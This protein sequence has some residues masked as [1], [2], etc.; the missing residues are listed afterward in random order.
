MIGEGIGKRVSTK[1]YLEGTLVEDALNYIAITGGVGGPPSAQIRIV[2]TNTARKI[3]PRTHV[4]VFATDPWRDESTLAPG[5]DPF[6]L[7]FEGEVLGRGFDRLNDN[8]SLTLHCLGLSN[9]W[10]GP[11][12][13]WFDLSQ[14][15]GEMTANI[16]RV[17]TGNNLSGVQIAV[18]ANNIQKDTYLIRKLGNNTEDSY[19]EAIISILDDIGIVNPFYHLVRNRYRITDR[20]LAKAAGDV[21]KL[22][23]LEAFLPWLQ[24]MVGKQGTETSLLQMI[25]EFLGIIYHEYVELPCPSLVMGNPPLRD[26]YGNP[27]TNQ[28]GLL[29]PSKTSEETV[30]SFL[31]KPNLYMLSPPTCNVLYPN[32]Y[33]KASYLNNFIGETTRLILRPT[34]PENLGG[35]LFSAVN[36]IARPTDLDLFWQLTKGTQTGG[37]Y[38]GV[39][40]TP[41]GTLTT[42]GVSSNLTPQ[43][44]TFNDFD[45]Y[46]NEEKIRG[47][48]YNIMPISPAATIFALQKGSQSSTVNY[49]E[50]LSQY[51][52]NIASYEYYKERFGSRTMTT[53]G[54]F[55]PRVVQGLPILLLDDS[56]AEMTMI[57]YLTQFTH[58]LSGEGSAVTTYSISAARF[59]DE[60][61]LNRPVMK[62]T[63][64][65]DGAEINVQFDDDGLPDFGKIFADTTDPPIPEWFSDDWKTIVGL[66]KTYQSL[67]GVD[68]IQE[69][70]FPQ[71]ET[72]T[73][74]NDLSI[75]ETVDDMITEYQTARAR[76]T[77]FKVA[78]TNTARPM[79]DRD[80]LFRFIGAV[81]KDLIGAKTT[82]VKVS[83]NTKR[84]RAKYRGV[85]QATWPKSGVQRN[86]FLT[87]PDTTNNTDPTVAQFPQTTVQSPVSQLV[88]LQ[89]PG[90][91]SPSGVESLTGLNLPNQ[92]IYEGRPVPFNFDYRIFQASLQSAI[93]SAAT[94]NPTLAENQS[95]YQALLTRL[96]TGDLAGTTENRAPTNPDDVAA[97]GRQGQVPAL[98]P[99][100]AEK[101]I[102]TMRRAVVDGY[103]KELQAIRGFK[104]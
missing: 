90:T 12:K 54:P 18:D 47:M 95:Q 58:V 80:S 43:A 2:P 39:P 82:E 14:S 26:V 78:S 49:K 85:N 31:F 68:V 4:A 93:K 64:K 25:I 29:Q 84:N 101:D 91:P 70:L 53:E 60:P 35:S 32:Q 17:M 79:V 8:R 69:R 92:P 48:V 104:G 7:V 77:E 102:V 73:D 36:Q 86:F 72:D 89:V 23:Q 13:W 16:N 37:K 56:D 1:L 11:K 63:G 45:Y 57:G 67:L 87:E 33:D 46:T 34:F 22:F 74:K 9:N 6:K 97:D 41:D 28:N 51:A 88:S 94:A 83:A 15:G 100:L 42:Q 96:T 20:V 98:A 10:L 30:G 65:G 24:G 66:E 44:P 75:Q 76:G 62:A 99:P 19:V 52:S 40:R 50:G 103:I 38:P 61:D 27:I 71:A 55:N 21:G 59:L 81:D 5:E 3:L